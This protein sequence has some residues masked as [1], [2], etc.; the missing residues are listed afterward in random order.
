MPL[1]LKLIMDIKKKAYILCYDYMNIPK[2]LFSLIH[3]GGEPKKNWP[4]QQWPCTW[5]AN[6]PMGAI[7]FSD[8]LT[9]N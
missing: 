7:G 5:G 2:I 1:F 9:I 6:K 3:K 4:L 8:F